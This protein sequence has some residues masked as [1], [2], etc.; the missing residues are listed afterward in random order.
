MLR[1]WKREEWTLLFLMARIASTGFFDRK[2][3]RKTYPDTPTTMS[4]LEHY[5][6]HGASEGR[7]PGPNF[8]SAWYKAKNP[9]VVAAGLDPLLHYLEHGAAE[10]RKPVPASDS[11]DLGTVMQKV[12]SSGFFDPAW[13]IEKNS[14]V[15]P[16]YMGALEHYVRHGAFEG[17]SPGPKFDSAWYLAQYPD[18]ASA[19]IDPLLHFINHG[20]AEGRKPAPPAGVLKTAQAVINSIADLEP[21]LYSSDVFDSVERLHI[22]DGRANGKVQKAFRAF[23]ESLPHTYDFIVFMPW[24]VHGGADRVAMHAVRALVE[25]HGSESTLVVVTDFDRVDAKR[26]LPNGAELRVFSLFAEDL[27]AHDRT[28]LVEL[29][30]QTLQPVSVLN[31]NSRACW[32]AFANRAAAFSTFT[33]LFAGIFCRDYSSDGRPAGY[34]DTHLRKSFQYLCRVYC[35]NEAFTKELVEHFA[36]PRDIASKFRVLRQPISR[37][38]VR[39]DANSLP[40]RKDRFTVLWASRVSRQKNIELLMQ[41]AEMAPHMSFEIWGSGDDLEQER[42]KRF[43][44]NNSNFIIRGTYSSFEALPHENYD[45]FL[46]T[47]SWDGIPNVLLEAAAADLPIVASAVGGIGELVTAETGWPI[48]DRENPRAYV[49]ALEQIRADAEEGKRRRINMCAYVE[50]NHSWESYV[51]ALSKKPSFLGI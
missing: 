1:L 47:S 43:A 29:V 15:P 32:D 48:A 27:S 4:A 24:L 31:V 39:T 46:Y 18:I 17:R 12:L 6:R 33:R 28:A 44:A 20:A 38:V 50:E 37:S 26:W 25:R 22:V 16:H 11:K 45:A 34:S 41:I 49:Q 21:D 9:D 23:F 35:D 51:E 14:D 7:S 3:Y 8:N 42:L 30:I 36:L 19:H 40:L 5:V 10:G 13:Y 2:W